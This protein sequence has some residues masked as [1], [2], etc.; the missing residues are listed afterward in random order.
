MSKDDEDEILELDV[1]PSAQ[2]NEREI[3]AMAVHLGIDPEQDPELLEIAKEALVAPNP[4]EWT[5]YVSTKDPSNIFYFNSTTCETSVEHPLHEHFKTKVREAL[6]RK[7][8]LPHVQIA[9]DPEP[10]ENVEEEEEE[11][12][13]ADEEDEEVA[14]CEKT[15]KKGAWKWVA[16]C[17]LS[18]CVGYLAGA[19]RRK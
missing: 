9:V 19:R 18:F 14:E 11:E 8:R 1:S 2:P 7:G 12:E 15:D 6:K 5:I 17:A 10:V 3:L 16:L 13:M 4:P